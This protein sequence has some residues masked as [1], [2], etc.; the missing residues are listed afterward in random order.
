VLSYSINLAYSLLFSNTNTSFEVKDHH[1]KHFKFFSHYHYQFCNEFCNEHSFLQ[2]QDL[3]VYF[4]KV[5]GKAVCSAENM[6]IYHD[7][8]KLSSITTLGSLDLRTWNSI[9]ITLQEVVL[10][11]SN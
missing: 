7:G 4:E 3:K 9:L 2:V 1:K 6:V 5:K 8:T 11:A 10:F